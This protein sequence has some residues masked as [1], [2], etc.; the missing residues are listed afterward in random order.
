MTVSLLR[1]ADEGTDRVLTLT[2]N[3]A[4]LIY[5]WV[6]AGHGASPDVGCEVVELMVS[7]S[8]HHI[9]FYQD[10]ASRGG[11]C[12]ALGAILQ[13][14]TVAAGVEDQGGFKAGQLAQL[15]LIICG[16]QCGAFP[17]LD[18]LRMDAASH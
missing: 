4:E 6:D 3:L 18:L 2:L 1:V 14:M 13:P 9:C 17:V 7:R 15:Q 10:K 8:M 12:C 11:V 16:T 5:A